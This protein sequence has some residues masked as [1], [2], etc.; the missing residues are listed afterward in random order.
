MMKPVEHYV[1]H[2]WMRPPVRVE[3]Q[4]DPGEDPCRTKS[5]RI[6]HDEAAVLREMEIV[7]CRL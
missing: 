2:C 1:L 7:V 5:R 6:R 3:M 4:G